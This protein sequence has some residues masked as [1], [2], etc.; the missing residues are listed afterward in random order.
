MRQA[1]TIYVSEACRSLLSSLKELPPLTSE[2]EEPFHRATELMSAGKGE[3]ACAVLRNTRQLSLENGNE[4]M[5]AFYSNILG[6][7]LSIAGKSEEALEAYRAAIGHEPENPHWKLTLAEHLLAVRGVPEEA[8]QITSE[9][10][11]TI[12]MSNAS[13]Y[14]AAHSLLGLA[15]LELEQTEDAWGSFL[16]ATAPG[17][18]EPLAASGCDLRLVA[19]LIETRGVGSLATYRSYLQ[20]V[21]RKATEEGNEAVV[22]AVTELL[23]KYFGGEPPVER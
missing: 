15:H 1:G 23:E 22:K 13:A 17:V 16:E 21:H 19:R 6:S 14:H 20:I 4:N 7:F 8:L 18:V 12:H 11:T 2:W 9:A 5:A 3:E 10:L